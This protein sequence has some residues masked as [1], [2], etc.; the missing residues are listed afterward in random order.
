[1]CSVRQNVQRN[2]QCYKRPNKAFF[3]KNLL[4]YLIR[5]RAHINISSSAAAEPDVESGVG[6]HV[7]DDPAVIVLPSQ[8]MKL[9][10]S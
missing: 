9:P 3:K 1:M 7:L 5:L 2:L 8:V 4:G 6:E 10:D